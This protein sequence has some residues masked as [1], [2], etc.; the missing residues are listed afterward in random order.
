MSAAH[1]AI[2]AADDRVAA[3]AK[4]AQVVI[5]DVDAATVE[6]MLMYC[7]GC[8]QQLP[9]DHDQV[10]TSNSPLPQFVLMDLSCLP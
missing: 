1:A 9:S 8:L 5:S 7:Y 2:V 10:I 3:Q 4:T 6:R